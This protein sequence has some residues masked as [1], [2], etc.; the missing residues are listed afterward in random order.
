MTGY[1]RFRVASSKKKR[2]KLC[3]LKLQWSWWRYCGPEAGSAD[4]VNVKEIENS[5]ISSCLW[6]KSTISLSLKAEQRVYETE[7]WKFASW[8]HLI[9][10]RPHYVTTS[11]IPSHKTTHIKSQLQPQQKGNRGPK[12]M[13]TVRSC[14]TFCSDCAVSSREWH[15]KWR[16]T[17]QRSQ[18]LMICVAEKDV[19]CFL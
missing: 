5:Q 13:F 6:F 17:V 3:G 16:V 14:G 18:N 15:A 19:F 9:K 4:R 11:P 7:L 10:Q 2:L 8:N 1:S 12:S